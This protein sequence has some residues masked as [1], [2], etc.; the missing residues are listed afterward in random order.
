MARANSWREVLSQEF[1]PSQMP[2][3]DSRFF[4]AMLII[5]LFFGYSKWFRYQA[6][7]LIPPI[8][9]EAS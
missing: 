6:Q 1:V 4:L 5:F 9:H 2:W 7:S 8:S 3:I